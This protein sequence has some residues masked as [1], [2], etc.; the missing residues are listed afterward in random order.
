MNKAD[1]T[2]TNRGRTEILQKEKTFDTHEKSNNIRKLFRNLR[3]NFTTGTT[4][5][6]C[7]SKSV[8]GWVGVD[9]LVLC[10]GHNAS[11][12]FSKSRRRL[13]EGWNSKLATHHDPESDYT[14]HSL[15]T[16]HREGT[17]YRAL[18]HDMGSITSMQE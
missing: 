16:P 14:Y 13:L 7:D 8:Q 4:T 9:N 12:L 5:F 17:P 15:T 6:S 2:K 3:E 10:R 1:F 11:I 18:K